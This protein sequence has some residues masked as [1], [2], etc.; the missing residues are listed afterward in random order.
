MNEATAIHQRGLAALA[1]GLAAGEFSSRELT[2]YFLARI[3][4]HDAALNSFISVAEEQACAAADAADARRAAGESAALLGVPIAHKD[5]FC[6]AGLRSSCGSNM[7]RDYVPPYDACVVRR[8]AAAGA[9]TLGKTN[10]DEFAMGSSN[11]TSAFGP[12]R[13]PWDAD[14]V[15]G[16]SSGGSAAAVAAGLCAA[17]TGTD[18]GGSIRQPAA[19]CGVTGLKPTYGRVSR[20]GMIAFASSLD[21]AGSLT[22]NVADAALLLSA[23]AGEDAADSTCAPRPSEDFSVAL[24]SPVDGL[25]L[26]VVRQWLDGDGAAAVEAAVREFESLGC[27][28]ESV[29]L[30][31]AE[32]GL[33]AYYVLA[34]AEC[35]SNLARYDGV[36]YGHRVDADNIG[37]LMQNSRESG[38]GAEVKRRILIGN[39]VLSTGYY[40]DYYRHAQRLRR[41]ILDDFKAAFVEV[42]A[43]LG[44][45]TMSSAFALGEKTSDPLRMYREDLFTIPASLAGLPAL[46]VP[47][48]FHADKPLGLHIVAPH[49]EEGRLL[50]LGHAFESRTD[51]HRRRSPIAEQV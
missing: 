42:D 10:M 2:E 6:T 46:S 26:G 11:E 29:E 44:A 22:L 4:R 16:G 41:R 19:L 23:M 34:P 25:R 36:R 51:W 38:F 9:V 17:A 8:L 3:K 24:K 49:F 27:E 14:A 40:D 21:Q 32:Q 30:P 1:D 33:P 35:C 37:D 47:C 39:Y 45:T 7:L 31:L 18:T 48:G 20:H 50:A 28:I 12:V 13:N 15:P 5:L 43:L